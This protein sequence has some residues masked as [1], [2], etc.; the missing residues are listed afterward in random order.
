MA[1]LFL[2]NISLMIPQHKQVAVTK[3]LQT[4]FG[5]T[6]YD[7]IQQITTGLSSALILKIIIKKK[8]YLLRV[9]TRTDAI[10]DPAHYFAA[11]QIGADAG[12]APRIHYLS[13][14]DRISI[15]DFIDQKPYAVPVA[16]VQLAVLL[17]TLHA[18][19]K[20]PFRMNYF[21]KME[22]FMK[23]FREAK[24]LSESSISDLFNIYKTV[25]AVYPR[26][27]GDNM[28]SCHND[29]KPENIIFDGTRTWLIDWEAAFLNDRYLDLA[30]IANFVIHHEQ[31]ETEYLTKYFGSTPTDYQ[32]A[33]LYLMQQILHVYYCVIFMLIGAAGKPV[34]LEKIDKPGLHA[35][36][37]SIWSGVTDLAIHEAKLVYG[38]AHFEQLLIKRNTSRFNESIMIVEEKHRL[39]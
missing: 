2:Q 30:V 39:I 34:D 27:D 22:G 25:A 28:V 19:P 4:A 24:I 7:S 33:R 29:L 15:T 14:E 18:L 3:A 23:S 35:F 1:I 5:V 38:W 20:F 11:M 9:I 12:L 37:Q 21:E 36:Q 8:S 10:A 31:D 16:R 32:R 6:T 17:Q 13:T 26:L